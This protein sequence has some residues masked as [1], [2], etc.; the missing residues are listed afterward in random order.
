MLC[1]RNTDT[2]QASVPTALAYLLTIYGMIDP[3]VLRDRELKVREMAYSL[4]ESL[5]TI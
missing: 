2:I 1:E 4:I 3:E 5:V